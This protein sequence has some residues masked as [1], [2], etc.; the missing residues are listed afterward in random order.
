MG[1]THV[2]KKIEVAVGI[3]CLGV[4][5]LIICLNV[6]M[7]YV[8]TAPI[9]WAEEVSNFLFVW[10]GFLSCAYVLAQDQHIRVTLF[11]GML[12][13]TVQ[14]WVSLAMTV[15]LMVVFAS[16]VWPSLIALQSLNL[17]A[18]LQ[19]SEVYPYAILPITMVLC[20]AHCVIRITVLIREIAAIRGEAAS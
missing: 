7:R 9:F 13:P 12:K 20:F 6:F 14:L 15:L 2:L 19:I 1:P 4:M 8:L 10:A 3:A 16:F 5:F 18:A 17:T 11:V